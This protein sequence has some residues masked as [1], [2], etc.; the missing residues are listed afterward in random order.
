MVNITLQGIYV[1][2]NQFSLSGSIFAVS[3]SGHSGQASKGNDIVCAGVSA[4]SQSVALALEYYEIAH[5]ISQQEGL[6]EF[7][8]NL[9]TLN[10]DKKIRCESLASVFILGINEIRKQYPEFVNV[11]I[12]E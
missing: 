1:K 12:Q 11:S 9:D 6:L 7:S 10:N 5:S 3:I 8:V 2:N 4:L